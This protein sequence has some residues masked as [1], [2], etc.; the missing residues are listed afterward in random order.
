MKPSN[1]I[2]VFLCVTTLIGAQLAR[3]QAPTGTPPE[4]PTVAP[5]PTPPAPSGNAQV[6]NPH[7]PP[8]K[9]APMDVENIPV[10]DAVA[11]TWLEALDHARYEETWDSAAP[12]FQSRISKADWIKGIGAKRG[13][14][15]GVNTRRLDSSA[16]TNSVPGAPIG[17]Y[18]TLRYNTQFEHG[19]DK[20]VIET[21]TC[22]QAP[23][24]AWHVAGY[25]IP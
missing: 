1:P 21:V 6:G 7:I 22:L 10:V 5:A 8:P 18:L 2:L 14:Y 3:A 25:S 15:G 13:P 4:T 17:E 24:G 20:P 11:T 9:V 16:T 12:I 19:S 23:N